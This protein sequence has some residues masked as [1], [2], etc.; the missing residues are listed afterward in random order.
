MT[1][2]VAQVRNTVSRSGFVNPL[3]LGVLVT[4]ASYV[5][6]YADTTLLSNGPDYSIAAASIGDPAGPVITIIGADNVNNYVG[7]LTFTALFDPPLDQQTDL[8]PGGVLGRS[9]ESGLDNQ[10]R[11]LQAVADDVTRALKLPV[12]VTGDIVLPPPV[13]GAYPTWDAD[14]QAF[15]WA[16]L[17]T[18]AA[19]PL[20]ADLSAI[21]ALSTSAYGR[22]L[23]TLANQAALLALLP[24]YQP[25]DSDLTSW[26]AVTRASGFDAFTATPSSANLRA[27]L[28]DETGTGSAV[29]G[30]APT[31]TG[32]VVT[33]TAIDLQV[34]QIKFPATQNPSANANTLDDYE[35]GTWT[36]TFV[37]SGATFSY[38]SQVGEY[39]RIGD[40][41]SWNFRI[42]LN[43]TGNSGFGASAVTVSGFPFTSQHAVNYGFGGVWANLAASLVNLNATPIGG[44]T[45]INLNANT[46][47]ATTNGTSITSNALSTTAGSIVSA[48]GQHRAA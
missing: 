25:L 31:I 1:Q 48:A 6:V 32:P 38:A 22:A 46:A 4:D 47:A 17:G 42:Q 19:Q 41:V 13:D 43:T 24:S 26:A 21:A 33:T 15:I 9:F 2:A 36:P 14:T 44:S 30:T 40:R 27:L 29:F 34:G 12:N 39:T 37:S 45:T 20:D 28:T 18:A 3:T 10:N 8:S 23:L 16:T 35:E 5:K 7:T 11:R